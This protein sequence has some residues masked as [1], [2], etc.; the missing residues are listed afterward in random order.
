M[1]L[2]IS[3]LTSCG[4]ISNFNAEACGTATT[5]NSSKYCI[6]SDKKIYEVKTGTDC[7]QLGTPLSDAGVYAFEDAN[8]GNGG[9]A[10]TLGAAGSVTTAENLVLYQCVSGIFT[11]TYGHIIVGSSDNKYCTITAEAGQIN[12]CS[13]TDPTTLGASVSK[14]VTDSTKLFTNDNSK[15]VV[16]TSAENYYILDVSFDGEDYCVD[17]SGEVFNRKMGLCKADTTGEDCDSYYN[18]SKGVCQLSNTNANPRQSSD[19]CIPA[20]DTQCDKGYYLVKGGEI[21]KD[22]TTTG[23]TLWFCPG[24]KDCQDKTGLLGFFNN[25]GQAE[26]YIECT[27][28]GCKGTTVTGTSCDSTAEGQAVTTGTFYNSG[29]LKL[30]IYDSGDESL[31]VTAGNYFVSIKTS[32]LGLKAL[33]DHFIAVNVDADGNLT[34]LKETIRYRYTLFGENKIH[35]REDAK[36]ETST[37]QI[38]DAG[39]TPFEYILDQWTSSS[40]ID[41]DKADYYVTETFYQREREAK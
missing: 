27:V 29:G 16:A 1:E 11:Q 32:L 35:L 23:A 31:T 25:K 38:C 9:T 37:N 18:C 3:S 34:V 13:S 33:T 2:I 39:V 41:S 20:A 6:H 17:K 22:T 4:N 21:I 8:D 30:C 24:G 14:L 26:Q 40:T 12:S 28:E 5:A 19:E 7:S 36:T 15:K 10:V